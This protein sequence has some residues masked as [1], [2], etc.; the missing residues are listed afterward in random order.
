M[1]FAARAH[2]AGS[3]A[4]PQGLGAM[5]LGGISIVSSNFAV[6]ITLTPDGTV[7]F[8]NEM[9]EVQTTPTPR[10]WYS[11][12]T[13]GVGTNY[14]VRFT[15]QSGTAWNAGLTSGTLYGLSSARS[16]AWTLPAE[17]TVNAQV[18][19][20]ITSASDTAVLASGVLTV[21]MIDEF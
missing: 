12:V 10:N 20:E 1:T 19:I 9:N 3:T 18:L 17:G 11:P 4:G 21:S 13:G 14:R 8:L 7:S 2:A 5:N 15:L 16:L 6:G